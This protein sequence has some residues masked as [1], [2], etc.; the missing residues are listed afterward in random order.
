MTTNHKNYLNL[1]FQLAERNLGCTKLNP[2]VGSIVVKNNTVISSAVTSINGRPHSE[3]NALNNL[4]NC[5]G[6]TLYTTL[7]P[8][9]HHGKTPPCVNIILKKKIKNIFYAFNDPDQRTYK[10]AN[11]FLNFHGI[12]TKLITTKKYHKFYKSYFLNKKKN[13]PYF[14]AKIAVSKDNFSINKKKKWI[15]NK[16]SRKIV[17]LLRHKH[18]CILSTSKS[19]NA[20]NSLL[21]C[22]INGLNNNNPDLVIIDL[23]L[24]LKKN[25]ALNKLL[26]KRK[27]YLVVDK[28]YSKKCNTYKKLGFKIIFLESLKNKKDFNLLSKKIYNIG[29]SRI[30]VEAGLT[31]LNFLLKHKIVDDLYI[32]QG[33]DKLEKNGKNNDVNKSIK[34]ILRKSHKI[35]LNENNLFIKSF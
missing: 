35:S 25:L 3:F 15:T 5:S 32:F 31:F 1:A 22:R 10:K 8:C 28:L 34:K 12:K 18:D 13:I 14:A 21:N 23:A 27:T 7:E 2:S 11:K 26:K 16:Y 29:Y 33:S 9:T 30:F 24:K 20:D 17:H 6:A 19:I 4:K